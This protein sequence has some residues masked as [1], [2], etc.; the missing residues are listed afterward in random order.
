MS[1]VK[2]KKV[3]LGTDATAS[4]NFTLYQPSTPDGTL[5]IGVGNADSPTEVARVNSDGLADANGQKLSNTPAFGA[6]MSANQ[7][8]TNVIHTKVMFD[9]KEFDTD[10]AFDVANYR[11]TVPSG[12]AGKYLI[13]ST[14]RLNSG[15]ASNLA[16]AMNQLYKNGTAIKT[17]YNYYLSGGYGHSVSLTI[18]N[19]LDLSVGDYI[20]VYA[21]MQ[22]AV[23]ASGMVLNSGVYASFSGHKLIT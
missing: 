1:T 19:I 16:V 2:T 5:R 14:L 20:E 13:N 10:N 6:S 23:T 4:N 22:G 11:F 15:S 3:Q 18:S 17:A 21:Y 8:I 12:K 9:T 7:N